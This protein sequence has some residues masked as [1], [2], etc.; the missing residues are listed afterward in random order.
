MR[1]IHVGRLIDH[2]HLR[3]SDLAA[4]KRFYR[5]EWI[6][7]HTLPAF[8]DPVE[9]LRGELDREAAVA[10]PAMRERMAALFRTTLELERDFFESAYGAA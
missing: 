9:G 6:A 2:V 5:A 3:A 4:A 8:A 7:L 10:Q 1:E